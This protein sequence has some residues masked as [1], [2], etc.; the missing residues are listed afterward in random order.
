[1]AVTLALLACGCA[2]GPGGQAAG[3][4]PPAATTQPTTQ[5][6]VLA[7]PPVLYENRDRGIRLEYLGDWQR[8]T[9]ADYVL[10]VVPAGQSGGEIELTLDVPDLP[11]H[12]P[13]M[14]P[15]GLVEKGYL[16]DL[17]KNHTGLNVLGRSDHAVPGARARLARS[18]WP[19]ADG[20]LWAEDALV[21]V[22]GDRVYILRLTGPAAAVEAQR[23]AFDET[24]RSIRWIK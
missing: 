14:I 23:P 12:L 2:R 20:G 19:T 15:L 7:P 5:P 24:A 11:P 3:S 22:H 17:K 13:G 18:T 10:R 1:V 4:P 21:M 9:S 6:A 16:D 8:V